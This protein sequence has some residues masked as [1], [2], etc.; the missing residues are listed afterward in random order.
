MVVYSRPAAMIQ[1]LVFGYGNSLSKQGLQTEARD[2]RIILPTG[3]GPRFVDDNGN[4][5]IG[6][7]AFD[8]AFRGVPRHITIPPAQYASMGLTPRKEADRP[9]AF[10]RALCE[11]FKEECYLS[12]SELR[13]AFP[14]LPFDRPH[15][16]A[17]DWRHP[18]SAEDEVPSG[19]PFFANLAKGLAAGK[20]D[21][22]KKEKGICTGATGTHRIPRNLVDRVLGIQLR[23]RP[24][25]QVDWRAAC[26]SWPVSWA[27]H[28]RIVSQEI[29]HPERGVDTTRGPTPRTGRTKYQRFQ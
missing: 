10:L 22:S 27:P 23:E 15:L 9:A 4:F 7:E 11:L 2:S 21:L 3:G 29:P 1:N 8:V 18:D 24:L 14:H 13:S 6:L 19:V 16:H 26:P 12:E 20:A 5:S 28:Y 17:D 25:P